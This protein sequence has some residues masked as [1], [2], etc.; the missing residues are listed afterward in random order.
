MV[1]RL[2]CSDDDELGWRSGGHSIGSREG[3]TWL[4]REVMKAWRIS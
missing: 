3:K 1:K 4:V 2:Y